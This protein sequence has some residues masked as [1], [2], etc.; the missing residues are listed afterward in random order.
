MYIQTASN[1]FEKV[2]FVKICFSSPRTQLFQWY[3]NVQKYVSFHG[4]IHLQ[5]TKLIIVNNDKKGFVYDFSI[6]NL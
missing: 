6:G 5:N 1:L 3:K 2:R 4:N